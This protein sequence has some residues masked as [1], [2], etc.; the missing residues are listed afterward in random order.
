[1][2]LDSDVSNAD[3]L[4]HVEFYTHDRDPYKGKPFVRIVVPGDKNNIIDQ[5][6][7]DDHRERFPRQ[8][9]WYQMQNGDTPAVGTP[10]IAWH[11][12]RPDDISEGQAQELAVLKFQT[13]EQLASGSDMQMQR[14]GMGGVGLRERARAYIRAAPNDDSETKAKLAKTE[15]ELETLKA[16]VAALMVSR[17]QEVP[18]RGPGRPASIARD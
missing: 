18:K 11:R 10:I 3:S 4:L 7:R 8:W 2:A 12:D 14:I 1:M 13:V 16:Q 5:P 15:A 17:I 6:V 9:M